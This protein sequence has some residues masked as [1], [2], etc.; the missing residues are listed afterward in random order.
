MTFLLRI[1]LLTTGGL[2]PSALAAARGDCP[3]STR[4]QES[5]T[6]DGGVERW[7]AMKDGTPHGPFLVVGP[8]G[9]A[10]ARGQMAQ[11]ARDGAWQLYRADGTAWQVGT[12]LAGSRV[13]AWTTLGV[14]KVPT[15]TL[16]H[17]DLLPGLPAAPASH[18][19]RV[20]WATPGALPDQLDAPGAIA[21]GAARYRPRVDGDRL[22]QVEGRQL[23]SID[24]A[25][26]AT[27]WRSQG[28]GA[29]LP[30]LVAGE[31]RLAV[32]T[33]SGLLVVVDPDGGSQVGIRTGL[34]AKV[35]VRVDARHAVVQ[36]GA[37][38]LSSWR[39]ET[40]EVE[41]TSRRAYGE[42]P[43]LDAGVVLL[44]A[45]G[46]EVHALDPKTGAHRWQATL[47]SRV[48]ELAQGR[49]NTV[50]VRTSAGAIERLGAVDGAPVHTLASPGGVEP[51]AALHA[52]RIREDADGVLLFAQDGVRL[53]DPV[54]G[55][56][57]ETVTGLEAT[58]DRF[59]ALACG[60]GPEG[61]LV[62]QGSAMDVDLPG[63][64]P[65]S[66]VLVL[67][68]LIV[69]PTAGGLVA[70]DPM[71]ANVGGAAGSRLYAVVSPTDGGPEVEVALPAR[72]VT[73]AGTDGACE[74][75]D[76]VVDLSVAQDAVLPN[77]DGVRPAFSL[78]I[79]EVQVAWQDG[80]SPWSFA[81][82]WDT[83][84]LESRWEATWMVAWRP[85]LLD[86]VVLDG[87][88]DAAGELD[89]LLMCEGAGASFR[90]RVLAVDSH[91]RLLFEGDIRLDPF[92]HDFDG[93]VGCLLD[94]YVN[95][96]DMG[97]FR[98]PSLPGWMDLSLV[99]T[100]S[101]VSPTLAETGPP[102]PVD[103]VRGDLSI[104]TLIPGELARRELQLSGGVSFTLLD[105]WPEGTDFGVVDAHGAV[106]AQLPGDDLR[107]ADDPLYEEW[108]ALTTRTPLSV[109][110]DY[111]RSIWTRGD[112]PQAE[113]AATPAVPPA[114]AA[115]Q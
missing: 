8:D 95:G 9:R 81:P 103:L 40:G 25:T 111:V 63:L 115:L 28:N 18:D 37:G 107:L 34:G 50:L 109:D 113:P 29:L 5:A 79:P 30:T 46:R 82:G 76:L 41:W 60:T 106:W 70:V 1:L 47:P 64:Q 72:E 86:V 68:D 10:L 11:G 83:E 39:V 56:I 96:E 85:A 31:T 53:L 73:R 105:A 2:T 98:G 23:A 21:S 80:D 100:G 42:V 97:P 4:P 99:Q 32:V 75:T 94:L 84:L 48:V 17:G 61:G 3:R 101:D 52:T 51:S 22:L 74:I 38:R 43:P 102:L 49:D 16:I 108:W 12:Y 57:R 54:S 65:V 33:A 89:A 19:P 112:C 87:S 91:K 59:E 62:C 24:L 20:R 7:C 78:S 26:G 92:L 114:D 13:G 66:S 6:R 14:D 67:G 90:G 36:D 15:A 77:E 55:A 104:E 35:P 110:A 27:Q 45:R 93:E 71:L 58:V 88:G 44:A 69:V